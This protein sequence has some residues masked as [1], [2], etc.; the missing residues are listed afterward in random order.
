MSTLRETILSRAHQASFSL[1]DI[2]L[3]ERVLAQVPDELLQD[4]F[5]FIE[6]SPESMGYL[7]NNL[8]KK[9][10]ALEKGDAELI[11]EIFEDQKKFLQTLAPSVNL[12]TYYHD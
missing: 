4:I 2:S 5:N 6:M 8:K 3:W 12:D 10:E 11:D 7:N 9:F 1:E